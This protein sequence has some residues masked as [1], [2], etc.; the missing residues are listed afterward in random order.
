MNINLNPYIFRGYD[1]RGVVPKD[2]NEDVAYLIGRGFA[3][4]ISSLNKKKCVIGY[5]NRISS[6]SLHDALI[7][8]ITENGIDVIDI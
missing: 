3:S 8:G 7:K 1:I 5:D 2:I 6:K 4:K